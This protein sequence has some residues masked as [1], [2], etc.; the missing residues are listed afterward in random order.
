MKIKAITHGLLWPM[1]MMQALLSMCFRPKCDYGRWLWLWEILEKG[2]RQG[3]KEHKRYGILYPE[4]RNTLSSTLRRN[5]TF[6]DQ[7][8]HKEIIDDLCSQPC[9]K[10]WTAP[11]VGRV[12][13]NYQKGDGS[14]IKRV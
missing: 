8:N 7:S 6:D 10:L 5:Q 14:G 3:D 11:S 1:C 12:M 9:M 2:K 4:F 13:Q